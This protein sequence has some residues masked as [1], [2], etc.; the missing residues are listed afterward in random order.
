MEEAEASCR[1]HKPCCFLSDTSLQRTRLPLNLLLS[2]TQLFQLFKLFCILL[3]FSKYQY[4]F[5]YRPD[6]Q[7]ISLK[8]VMGIFLLSNSFP[9]P[10]Y[11]NW[12]LLPL[13]EVI[14]WSTKCL[15]Q[16]IRTITGTR[17]NFQ[18]RYSNLCS[19]KYKNID[20]CSFNQINWAVVSV[21]HE[22]VSLNFEEIQ[23]VY[24]ASWF[25]HLNVGQK[26]VC[27]WK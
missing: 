23:R 27:Y 7:K 13:A 4:Q 25:K 14:M 26:D 5:P 24:Y 10:L 11:S 21:V 18:T 16:Q 20:H 19:V 6:P 15:P 1:R 22:T 8:N 12:T 17:Q 3:N 9:S 2:L